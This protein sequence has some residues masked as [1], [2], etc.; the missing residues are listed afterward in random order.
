MCP[1]LSHLHNAQSATSQHYS[2]LP[3]RL[4]HTYM[5]KVCAVHTFI[6]F[7]D[8]LLACVVLCS[9]TTAVWHLMSLF[10]LRLHRNTYKSY[11]YIHITIY[12]HIYF[13]YKIMHVRILIFDNIYSTKWYSRGTLRDFLFW[14]LLMVSGGMSL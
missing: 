5:C 13:R 4:I 12:S 7:V 1:F 14:Q 11:T 2:L 9:N 10:Y 3:R 8:F 6:G